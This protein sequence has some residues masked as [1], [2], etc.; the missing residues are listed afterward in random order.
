VNAD[1]LRNTFTKFF[2]DRGHLAL[3]AASLV[4][5]D[6][7]MLFTIA[8]MVQFKPYFL[9]E[10]PPPGP[11]ATT[12]QPC[13]RTVDIDVIGTTSRHVTFF[14]MLGNFSFGEYFK[15]LAIAYAWELFTEGLGLDPE[16]L[17]V[18][19]H[20]SDDE[21]EALWRDVPGLL[22]GRLQRLDEDNFWKM[23]ETGP[24]GPCSEI[25]FDRGPQYGP[26]GGPAQGGER[27]VELWNLVFMQYERHHDGSL[28]ELPRRNIDTGAGLD[29][30]LTQIQGV[31][32]VFDTDL[33]API[34]EA[35]SA[36]TGRVYGSTEETDIG[37]RIVADHARTLTFLISDGVFPSNESRGY[38]LRR[39]IRRA[40]LVAQRLGA[41]GL[42][43]PGVIDVVAEVMA[44][45]YPKL[46]RDRELIKRIALHEEEAFLRTLRSGTTLLEAELAAGGSAV[47]GDVAF[48]LHDTYGFPIDL[49]EEIARERGIEVD[50][51][52]FDLAMA[53]QRQR[54]RE[55]G[56]A[57]TSAPEGVTAA[58]SEIRTVFGPTH[59]LGYQEASVE[60]RIL[61]VVPSSVDKSFAN[62]DGESAPDGAELIE[63]FLD[64]SPFYA[65]GGGQVGDTGTVTT[66]TGKVRVLD[67]TSV[68]EGLTRHL[69]YLIEGSIEAGQEAVA[70]I[71]SDRRESIRRNHT[72][73]HLLH[74][75]LRRVL[76]DH[77]R[78]QG[79]LVAPDR[80]RFD[81]SHFGP[82]SEEEIE[83]VEDLVNFEVLANEPVR[84]HESTREQAEGEGAMA[85][86][87]EKYGDIVRVVEAGH[88]S[89]ELCGGTHVSSLG[90]IGPLQ[91]VSEASI[92]SNTRRIEAVTGKASLARLRAFE[93]TVEEASQRLRT[94][95]SELTS[96]LDRLLVSQRVLEEELRNLRSDQLRNEAH[97]LAA[98]AFAETAGPLAGRVVGRRD[99]LDAGELRDLA[100]AVRDHPGV[101]AVG[102]VG[103]TGPERVALVVATTKSSGIDARAAAVVAATAVGGGGGGTP[104]LATAGGR[105]L[106]GVAEAVAKLSQAL[107]R[108]AG[109]PVPGP[110][111]APDGQAQA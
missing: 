109:E 95:P 107:S 66:S 85:F 26:G 32:S 7:T 67:A 89:V 1:Q 96:S 69:G 92:G 87:G 103:V 11:R 105:N 90:T 28:T 106:A 93:H 101:E 53:E 12:V 78:Q 20:V 73:T 9:G 34:L 110:A 68:V 71:E 17:W 54:A 46:Q 102:L 70:A 55:A 39:L 16:Q 29:R 63:V 108:S 83:R 58:W 10:S 13:V 86:F 84:I 40:V 36:A 21:A 47:G 45:A 97:E 4:P 59:F 38:V 57:V 19:V 79:S 64:R 25:F 8:G 30:I 104:E 82:M 99:G 56:R 51:Q 23:G 62:I 35:A 111:R 31:E 44:T 72:G 75:A 76:G 52:G 43:T 6:P 42:V 65:E 24:C 60:S 22:G 49:T 41:K 14:E 98:G 33:V 15:D 77:V 2:V 50:R 88:H 91:V 37:L 94:Q 61:A 81:F 18:T 5:N 80:L 48:Q 3:P 100:I 74:W 27:Y